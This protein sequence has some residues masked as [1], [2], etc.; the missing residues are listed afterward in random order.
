MLTPS[1]RPRGYGKALAVVFRKN[2]D[3][4]RLIVAME[5]FHLDFHIRIHANVEDL[6]PLGKP[7][8][9]PAAIVTNSNGGYAIDDAQ[10]SYGSRFLHPMP[11]GGGPLEIDIPLC[12]EK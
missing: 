8:I 10:R 9:R 3:V 6:A 12:H 2:R 5:Y 11:P 1:T 4:L 7:G